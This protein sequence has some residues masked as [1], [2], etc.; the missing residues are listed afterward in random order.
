MAILRR[1]HSSASRPLPGERRR[2]AAVAFVLRSVL[3]VMLS[4]VLILA[5][6]PSAKAQRGAELNRLKAAFIFQ[7]TNFVEWPEGTF[8]DNSSP[9]VIGVVG[10]DTVKDIIES[11]VQRKLIAGRKV[12]VR[13]FSSTGDMS[14]CHI[15]FVDESEGRNAPDIVDRHMD[16]PILT[17]SDTDSFTKEGGVIRLYQ[18]AN[19]LRIEINV[20]A[21]ERAK[22]KISSKLLSLSRLVRDGDS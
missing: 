8:E 17:I 19:K 3:M 22:L 1:R 7:F 2:G 15:I 5:F 18:Q 9:F 10:N 14:S 6:S 16:R 12:S 11:A 21:A 13:S 20:D 4:V